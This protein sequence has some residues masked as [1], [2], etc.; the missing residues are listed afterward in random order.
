MP[1]GNAQSLSPDELYALT[2]YILFL[3]DVTKDPNFELN[4]KNLASV[5]MPNAEQFYDDDRE[6][7]E[8]SFWN[9]QPCMKDCKKAVEIAGP[10]SRARRHAGKQDRTAGGLTMAQPSAG[11]VAV[12][13][14]AA[15]TLLPF[16]IVLIAA[17]GDLALGRHLAGECVTCHP[18]DSAQRRHS[19]DQRLA[20]GSVRRG[21][22]VLQ[23]KRARQSG[24][25]ER[26]CRLERRGDGRAGRVFR[27]AQAGRLSADI[28]R[29]SPA[30]SSDNDNQSEEETNM[31][32][33]R[34]FGILLGS[35]A[36]APMLA[37]PVY[38][39]AKARVVV[40]GGGP[41]GATA[42]KYIA[43]ESGGAIEVTLVEPTK[44]FITC[45]HSNLYLG[46]FKPL[47]GDHPHL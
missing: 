36:A 13:M 9:K 27:D 24:D 40:I 46:G 33:R 21:P 6:K 10:R 32:N 37:A 26:R 34:Q 16:G 7:T 39:Q 19:R 18:R 43:K 1:F 14:W 20:G 2:A 25:A 3:N 45:F 4:E 23:G 47:G 8:K 12:A 5:K 31:M 11:F 15:A 41:G 17:P 28:A 42:A 38:A 22:Q 30:S 29:K 35:S 44:Q